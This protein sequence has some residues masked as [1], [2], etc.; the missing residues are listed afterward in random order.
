MA[1][2]LPVSSFLTHLG[3]RLRRTLAL[4]G[5]LLL[6]SA[7]A[8][9]QAPANDDCAGA[10]L[11]PTTGTPL[12]TTN[13]GATASAGVADPTCSVY[14]GGDV[15]FRVTVP[16][17]GNL[18]LRASAVAGSP[19]YATGLAVYSGTCGSLVDVD[20]RNGS[21]DDWFADLLLRDQ[22]P[23]Q[24]LLVR[25]WVFDNTDLG[26]Y[27]L[28]A[29]EVLPCAAPTHLAVANLHARQA[30]ITFTEN[31]LTNGD[32]EVT[33]A[34]AGGGPSLTA[35]H[36]RSPITI[37]DLLPSTTYTATVA[38]TCG[39]S[40]TGPSAT[41]T[42]TTTAAPANDEPCGAL[43][44]TVG[45]ACTPLL[46][47]NLDAGP[48]TSVPDPT[49]ADYQGGDMWYSVVVPASG[50]LALETG[51]ATNSRVYNTGLAVYSGTCGNL[52]A[53]TCDDNS[54]HGYTSYARLTGLTP[55]ATLYV[56][57]WANG[58]YTKG[59]FTL[60]ATTDDAAPLTE[61]LGTSHDW[62][63]ATNWTNGVPTAA[64]N[65]HIA[66]L[67]SGTY[68]E[69]TTPSATAEVRSLTIDKYASFTH[70]AGTLAVS[71][72]LV[73]H[74]SYAEFT[75]TD[76]N[77]YP[78]FTIGGNIE[79]RG[80]G[81]QQVTGLSE[82][83]DLTMN[84]TGPATLT[85]PMRLIDRISMTQG[86]LSTGNTSVELYGD[87]PY[88]E[89]F[90][91]ASVSEK[92]SSYIIGEV[93]GKSFVDYGT[94]AELNG[95]GL[96]LT[97]DANASNTPGGL[98]FTRRTGTAAPRVG[99]RAGIT[100]SFVLEAD[101]ETD[102]DLTMNFQYFDHERNG[103]ATADLGLY[104]AP[105]PGGPWQLSPGATR[106]APLT[107]DAASTLTVAGLTHLSVWTLGSTETPLPVELTRFTAEA[108]GPAALLRWA[109]ATE[110]NSAYF[111]I[112]ASPDGRTF[113]P[114][115]KVTAHGTT[116]QASTYEFRDARLAEYGSRTVYYRLRQV[117]ADGT[118]SFSPVRSIALAAQSGAAFEASAFPV[119]FRQHLT[120]Q[121]RATT[122][123]PARL[124]LRDAWG[125]TLLQQTANA[126]IG[127]QNLA[128]DG[129]ERLAPGIYLLTIEQ[130]GQ[131]HQLKVSRE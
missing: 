80:T 98:K 130:N 53:L 109:T 117:D 127:T 9:A 71:G 34:P 131:Q 22:T 106:Q 125:R 54:G 86:V 56:R 55:G 19:V 44:L 78:T 29:R 105:S 24:T 87:N 62:F 99:T 94:P 35:T 83:Y 11:L 37:Q 57:V 77:N 25:S 68:P 91:T 31:E 115:D 72:N 16:A 18:R 61:W 45:T 28:S 4:A 8:F 38:S 120:V 60:C 30:D 23:G 13:V 89:F 73:N 3:T 111:A 27:Q 6:S 112:E 26:A 103:I 49:C 69:L 14:S 118:A 121:L 82:V 123:G 79:L 93:Y 124:T 7:S 58:N 15:W 95:L 10:T 128:L 102:L 52:T 41:L 51:E 107:A 122:A 84:G 12:V 2:R 85:T 5:T 113:R 88:N 101:G 48:S 64:T 76:F 47:S 108:A 42:F 97:S 21:S 96:T 110:K 104:S 116:T 63:A 66:N 46:I 90:S 20:C 43:P 50:I 40:L 126:T 114:V 36:D 129:T 100:R 39:G 67:P 119:P 33:Y 74:S 81:P 17:S 65:A 32:Y 59:D 92:E 75:Y 1:F 70:T